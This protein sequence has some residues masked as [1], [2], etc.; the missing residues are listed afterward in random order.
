MTREELI[1]INTNAI[2]QEI[3][4]YE[5]VS[6][7][8]LSQAKI[9]LSP[10]NLD[11]LAFCL[12]KICKWLEE[13]R[14]FN[15]NDRDYLQIKELLEY[16]SQTKTELDNRER[17]VVPLMQFWTAFNTWLE[18]ESTDPATLF[19][20][21]YQEGYS[22]WG[23]WFT[24]GVVNLDNLYRSTY[25]KSY[26]EITKENINFYL[27]KEFLEAYYKEVIEPSKGRLTFTVKINELLTRFLLPY[28]LQKGK[29]IQV[30]YKT[31][32]KIDKIENYEQFERKIEYAA[33]M[34]LHGD[35][36]DKHCAL[37]YIADAF[38]YFQ[39]L[40]KDNCQKQLGE[41]VNANNNSR[42]YSLIKNEVSLI[43]KLINDDFDIRHNEQ[44]SAAVNGQ[45]PNRE[46]L[47]DPIFIEY[48]YNRINALLMLLRIKRITK[49]N[50]KI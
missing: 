13:R 21:K 37:K 29:L 23:H 3:H 34:I 15:P 8:Y 4:Q 10:L 22:D 18:E 16:I 9:A 33:E 49:Q 1:I 20:P 17:E 44:N 7:T 14:V 2:L 27:L 50:S 24:V 48:L 30:G 35:Y 41:L 12:E 11:K 25:G 19:K 47:D 36:I 46:I 40:Y 38:C 31:T 6:E 45:H 28:K 5:N 39:S 32:Y 42:T 26:I 43:G